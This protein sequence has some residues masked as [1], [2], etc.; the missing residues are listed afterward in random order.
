MGGWINGL[1]DGWMDGCNDGQT[2]GWTYGWMDGYNDGQTDVWTDR[3]VDDQVCKQ[4]VICDFES[5][6]F[7]GDISQHV[8]QTLK[9]S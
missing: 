9:A 6:I 8:S 5:L 4:L 7:L 3:W 2:D 1:T